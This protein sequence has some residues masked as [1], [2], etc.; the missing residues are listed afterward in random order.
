[1]KNVYF[2]L[3]NKFAF[4]ENN[5]LDDIFNDDSSEICNKVCNH[6][7]NNN[8]IDLIISKIN[9]INDCIYVYVETYE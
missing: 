4:Q 7:P 6:F 8:W 2:Y 5:T 3:N 1:M 9:Y